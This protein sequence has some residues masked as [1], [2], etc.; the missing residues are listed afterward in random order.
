MAW[1]RYTNATIN[2]Q[3]P[4][5]LATCDRCG[6]VHNHKELDWQY[7]W[8]GPRLQN[9]GLLVCDSCMDVPQQNGRRTFIIPP[10]PV[11]IKNPRPDPYM[12]MGQSSSPDP[13]QSGAPNVLMTEDGNPL[14]TGT[15]SNGQVFTTEQQT[16]PTPTSSGY[17]V[18]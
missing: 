5:A 14:V 12:F 8:A 16:T 18:L 11:P 2:S 7:D 1:V 10:D 3:S 15:S 17:T 13:S 4:Q 9:Q 6:F